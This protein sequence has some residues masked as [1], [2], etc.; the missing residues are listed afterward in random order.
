MATLNYHD[1]IAEESGIS[2]VN[3]GVSG[4]GYAR[5]SS[6]GEAFHVRIL[7][8]PTDADIVTIFGSFN[9]IGANLEVGSITDTGTTT[10]CGCIN[11]T[12]DNLFDKFPLV[13]V[14]IITP[15][16]WHYKNLVPQNENTYVN[17]II[18]IARHR[19]I[20]CL[21]LFHESGLRP[22][23]ET[24]RSIAYSNDSNGVHPDEYGHEMIA[25]IIYEFI[26]KLLIN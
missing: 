9:D 14:G 21:D 8:I 5:K 26:K 10:L 15:T 12:I 4:T 24:F 11:T 13:R 17:A 18:N 16:P 20:P 2:V 25:P 22:W 1:Y 3:M 23:D 7:G 19:G 6:Y